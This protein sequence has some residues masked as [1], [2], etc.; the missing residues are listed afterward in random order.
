MPESSRRNPRLTQTALIGAIGFVFGTTSFSGETPSRVAATCVRQPV[1]L[2]FGGEGRALY[3]AN[4]RSGSLSVIDPKMGK[5]VAEVAVGRGLADVAALPDGRHLLVVDQESDALL[6]I[7]SRGESPRVVGRTSVSHDPVSVL[8]R[9]NGGVVA[10]RASRTLTFVSMEGATPRVSKTLALP[11]SPRNMVAL[12]AEGRIV[13]ADAVGGML[14]IVDPAR[15]ELK[16]VRR[17]Q[18]HNIR[19]LAVS[20]DGRSLAVAHQVLER[21][22]RTARDDVHFGSLMRNTLRVLSVEV[23]LRPGTDR[24][25]LDESRES[26]L[27][28][29][30]N[31]AGDPGGLVYDKN[32]GV[33]LALAGVG[34][35]MRSESPLSPHR[36]TRAGIRPT[37]VTLSPD[38]HSVYAVDTGG[39]AVVVVG[40]SQVTIAL[41]PRP[42]PDAIERGERLFH[43]ARLSHDHWLS[44]QSC[45][46]DNGTNGL[47]ADTMGDG[48][49]GTPKL[50]PPLL[51]V[52]DTAP[53]A[54]NGAAKRLEDQ[55]RKS[56]ESTM[57]GEPPTDAQVADLTAYLRSLPPPAAQPLETLAATR[58]RD[59]FQARRCDRCHTPPTYTA[60][61]TYDVGIS[62]ETG[63]KAF[64]PPSLR[65]VG[66]RSPLF[67][68]GR[69]ATL[70]DALRREH[71]PRGVD[72]SPTEVDDLIAFLR[73]L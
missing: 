37:A 66:G 23:V 71:H 30:G 2:C 6:V 73:T 62:D 20:P 7:D 55:V 51:G 34:E 25:L 13:V 42:E 26:D 50:V 49:F 61:G 12:S 53:W 35:I 52:A 58:G 31:G 14:A 48:T 57:Q 68:D 4:R 32:G 38:G 11:F 22:A 29:F 33:A 15:G 72:M 67:H 64:N 1:A 60:T 43:D 9:E 69:A 28:G 63:Q 8:V 3:V 21:S 36:R 24:E 5:V 40:A 10:S 54:W 70:G 17:L 27:D 59:V 65:G 41:G 47:L 16:A 18:G 19:G 45:H 46:T 56:I 44:C 39:D